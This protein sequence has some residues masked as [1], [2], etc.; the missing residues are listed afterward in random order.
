[1][2]SKA[3]SICPFCQA[4]SPVKEPRCVG[5]HRSLAGL[6]LAV[7][8]TDLDTPLAR[9]E[10]TPLQD[11]PLRDGRGAVLEPT[12]PPTPLPSP[13][14]VLRGTDRRTAPPPP[15]LPRRLAPR[16]AVA[17]GATLLGAILVGGLLVRAQEPGPAAPPASAPAVAAP[18]PRVRIARTRA[19]ATARPAAARRPPAPRQSTPAPTAPPTSSSPATSAT[20][21]TPP[22]AEVSTVR[23]DVRGVPV[24]VE[25]ARDDFRRP[26]PAPR[27]ERD[28]RE[29]LD[30]A[31]LRAH[32]RRAEAE[33]ARLAGRVEALRERA[34]VPV[35]K[36]VEEHQRLQAA[37]AAALDQLDELDA[38]VARLRRAVGG[39]D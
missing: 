39:A 5:C 3:F 32:L 35:V 19:E 29:G 7:Y 4:P 30:L 34:T 15:S 21:G 2:D 18:A 25:R 1:M 10:A 24:D 17:L 9:A 36:D 23:P 11:L 8:G 6:R 16:T 37:L 31:V 12:P 27:A 20:G 22:R 38:E 33:R 26:P 28:P 14:P 13:P